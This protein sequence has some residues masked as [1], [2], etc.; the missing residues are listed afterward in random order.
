MYAICLPRRNRSEF[1]ARC[2]STLALFRNFDCVLISFF[3]A[4]AITAS[5]ISKS[6]SLG[7]PVIDR[8]VTSWSIDL[9]ISTC[10]IQHSD[11]RMRCPYTNF[12]S[13]VDLPALKFQRVKK[14]SKI[15]FRNRNPRIIHHTTVRIVWVE[16]HLDASTIM[17]LVNRRGLGKAKHCF[18]S[19]RR[20][21]KCS[22]TCMWHGLQWMTQNEWEQQTGQRKWPLVS[23]P[24]TE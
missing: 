22:A 11:L 7:C 10:L 15:S 8:D 4:D 5:S 6:W 17:Y 13:E 18:F 24:V 23:H 2:S 1:W 14:V 19:R 12:S 9:S 20:L 16:P 21:S 3:I